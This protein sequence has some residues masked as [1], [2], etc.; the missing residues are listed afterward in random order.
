MP[1]QAKRGIA[2]VRDTQTRPGWLE[3]RVPLMRW[4]LA[5]KLNAQPRRFSD[6]LRSTTPLPIVEQSSRD[7][8]W[9]ARISADQSA[10]GRPLVGHNV[11]GRLLTEL[12]DAPDR[13]AMVPAPPVDVTLLGRRLRADGAAGPAGDWFMLVPG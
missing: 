4:C 9:G 11:L 3:V 8:F 13:P 5:V 2:D 10:P 12:R 7:P 1:V 6:V